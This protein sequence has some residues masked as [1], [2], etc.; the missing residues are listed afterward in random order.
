[1][2]DSCRET[3]KEQFPSMVPI[4]DKPRTEPKQELTT[5]RRELMEAKREYLESLKKSIREM[6]GTEEF[7]KELVD[8]MLA[9]RKDIRGEITNSEYSEKLDVQIDKKIKS[10]M[11]RMAH[12]GSGNET[13]KVEVME[14]DGAGN[15]KAIFEDGTEE[16]IPEPDKE[17]LESLRQYFDSYRL[18]HNAA[19][20]RKNV[21]DIQGRILQ[22]NKARKLNFYSE[23]EKSEVLIEKVFE[24][25]KKAG[26]EKKEVIDLIQTCNLEKLDT[27]EIQ[28]LKLLTKIQGIF[29]RFMGGDKGKYVGLSA[30]LMV[31]AFLEGY[32]PMFLANAFK[33]NQID[34]TQVG[35]F[36][37]LSVASAGGSTL[38][39]KQFKDFLDRN[40]SKKDG[41]GEYVAENVSEFPGAEVGEFGME[42]IKS[43]I[44]NAKASYEEILRKISF[45][46]LPAS[47]T[48]ATSAVMLYE[49]SSLLATGTIAGTGMMM[50]IDR[51]VDKKGKFWEKERRSATEAEKMSQKMSEL[52]NAHMEVI[53]SGEK[54]RLSQEMEELLASERM[55]MSDKQFMRVI[56]DKVA[57]STRMLNLIIAAI[58]T[59]IAGGSA[60]KFIAALVYSGNFNE[61]IS[62]VLSAKHDLLSSFRD[63]VQMEVMFN[64]YAE[65]E[66][67]KEKGRIGMSELPNHNISLKDVSVEFEKKKILDGVSLEIASGSLISLEGISG[68]GK[69]TLMKVMAGYYKPTAG[70]VEIGGTDMDGVKKSGRDSIYSKIAYLSQFPYILEDDVKSNLT[71]GISGEITDSE[72]REILKEVGLHGRFPNLKER[73]K[74]GRGDMG[75]TSGGETSRIGLARV[76][77]KMRKNASRI[78][79][80]DEP[81]ASVDEETAAE[82]AKI[83]NAEKRKN[84]GV[85]FISISHDKNFREM[86]DTT[87]VVKIRNGRIEG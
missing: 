42:R 85:T 68:S 11:Y 53:L 72:I 78:V 3:M 24:R 80:L 26:F 56:R 54:G 63:I 31:P 23:D 86:L 44:A 27:L 13:K 71:F 76:I 10:L 19:Q 73:L 69:T 12:Y 34:M 65:E 30:A 39:N 15:I 25:Y 67:E 41:F 50:A 75:T 33:E 59:Y 45:D 55:A 32:A 20:F 57:E 38:I 4:P 60:D 77:L 70:S 61:G 22:E 64:G 35:L 8:E 43:R 7:P 18:A 74:G 66:R 58:T 46:I 48:L 1:M 87:Q 29:S 16:N 14:E 84:P 52:L 6:F 47:V 81:T 5:D 40:F 9:I 2:G 49:K 62:K 82:I 51:Y 28:D 17:L 83:I 37:L 36:S 79:F 21:S